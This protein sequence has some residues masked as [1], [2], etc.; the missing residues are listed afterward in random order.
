MLAEK[1]VLGRILGAKEEE[2]GGGW[3]K[4]QN[5]KLRNSYQALN[6]VSRVK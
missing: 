3:R 6:I 4:L 1:L 5:V 2:I